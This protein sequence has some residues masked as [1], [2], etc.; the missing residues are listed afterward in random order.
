[1]KSDIDNIIPDGINFTDTLTKKALILLTEAPTTNF[2]QWC[3]I[4]RESFGSAHRMSSSGFH[5]TKIW[6][7]IIFQLVYIFAILYEN[8]IY[9]EEITLNDNFYIKDININPTT[10]GSWIYKIDNLEFYVPNYGYILMF[11]SKYNDPKST[12]KNLKILSTI[13]NNPNA[14]DEDIETKQN[15]NNIDMNTI[16]QKIM[17]KFLQIID[18]NKFCHYAKISGANY[19]SD[20]IINLLN[21]IVKIM[22]NKDKDKEIKDLFTTTPIFYD[23]LHNRMGTYLT[24]VERENMNT[25]L[26][27]SLIKEGDLCILKEEDFKWA[28]CLKIKPLPRARTRGYGGNKYTY[29]VVCR[30]KTKQ[31]TIH[32]NVPVA[33]IIPNL[34]KILQENLNDMRY[35][36]SYIFET[37]TFENKICYFPPC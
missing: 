17:N 18:P 19:P 34:E 24:K 30:N 16:K 32:E 6:K 4:T 7:C 5:T 20:E 28:I 8:N 31:L 3:S 25:S 13:F 23:Y 37:Y 10:M 33:R 12:N 9:M 2:S 26:I 36:G 29:T 35:D 11:D 21:E 22:N 27:P 15:N 14:S 1:M